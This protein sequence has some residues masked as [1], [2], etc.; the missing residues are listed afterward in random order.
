MPHGQWSRPSL[1]ATDPSWVIMPAAPPDT[2][3]AW[4]ARDAGGAVT[5]AGGCST[6]EAPEPPSTATFVDP[7]TRES[8]VPQHLGQ[9]TAGGSLRVQGRR[10]AGPRRDE[11]QPEDCPPIPPHVPCRYIA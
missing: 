11:G 8:L 5:P 6:G 7:R 9:E 1:N 4:V 3:L 2:S 10:H